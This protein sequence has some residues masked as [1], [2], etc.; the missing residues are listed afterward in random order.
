MENNSEL[1]KAKAKYMMTPEEIDVMWNQTKEYLLSKIHP[2]TQD[3][4]TVFITGGQPGSGKSALVYQSKLDFKTMGK[5]AE[6]LDVDSFRGFC[7]N[8][9]L[10]ASEYPEF[11]SQITDVYT[12]Y[13]MKRLLEEAITKGYNFIFEGTLANPQIIQTIRKFNPDYRIIA[14]IMATS[15]EESTLS[16]FERYLE[17][18]KTIGF[19]RLTTIEA[20]DVRFASLDKTVLALENEGI[21]EG[22]EVEVFERG[23]K[24]KLPVFLYGTHSLKSK[25]PSVEEALAAGRQRSFENCLKTAPERLQAINQEMA[26]EQNN[27]DMVEELKKLNTLFDGLFKKKEKKLDDKELINE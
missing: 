24:F 4:P 15:K 21:E 6:V 23:E 20:H 27:P 12:G 11:Y 2:E 13:I 19:G 5:Q 18:R 10:L 8:A 14:R 3:K 22:I 1:E 9:S 16:L 25:Y 26:Q 17:M 7:K